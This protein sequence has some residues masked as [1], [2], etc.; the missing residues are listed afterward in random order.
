MFKMFSE[1]PH[2]RIKKVMIFTL[3]F[4]MNWHG[5]VVFLINDVVWWIN[6]L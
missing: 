6:V 3:G 2:G 4:D 1:A 5:F